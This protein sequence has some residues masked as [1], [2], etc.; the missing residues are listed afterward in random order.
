MSVTYEWIFPQCE[1]APS[2][3]GLTNVVTAVHWRL[4][5][6]DGEYTAES[7]GRELLGPVADPADFT[8]FF[9]LTQQ[10]VLGWIENTLGSQYE[11]KLNDDP[12]QSLLERIKA[13]LVQQIENQ[14]NPPVVSRNFAF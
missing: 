13:D 11:P 4:R 9:S 7:F 2:K 14:K 3:D 12:K 5:A 8:D 6:T 1:V 10:Q